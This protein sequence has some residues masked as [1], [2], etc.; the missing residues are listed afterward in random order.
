MDVILFWLGAYQIDGRPARLGLKPI[1][2]VGL[3]MVFP[4]FG[5]S[6]RDIDYLGK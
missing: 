6:V 4:G 1:P 2:K 3:C 5:D